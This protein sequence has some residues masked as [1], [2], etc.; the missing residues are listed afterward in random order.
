VTCKTCGKEI[1][2]EW[3]KDPGSRPLIYC[4][5]SCSAR[6]DRG[7]DVK[8]K[9]RTS[10]QAR[11]PNSSKKA[12]RTPQRPARIKTCSVCENPFPKRSHTKSGVCVPCQKR[13][14]ERT[15]NQKLLA[16]ITG[17]TSVVS[18]TSGVTKGELQGSW[19]RA[20]KAFLLEESA[21][22]CAICDQEDMWHGKKVTFIL[23]HI[24]GD[25]KNQ[26]RSNLRVV[27]PMCDTLLPTFKSRNRGHGRSSA[28]AFYAASKEVK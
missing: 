15:Y 28:R 4:S 25:A 11:Y 27:C 5:R 3:R 13:D 20:I 24:D 16:W 1:S 2:S 12:S 21:H 26:S 19:S 17:D 8:Q 9:I 10:L 14:R 23:D 18:V 7:E 6:R 22:K